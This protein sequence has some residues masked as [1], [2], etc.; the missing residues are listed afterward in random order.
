MEDPPRPDA[1]E[2]VTACRR[3]HVKLA[4]IPLWGQADSL[5]RTLEKARAA[6]IDVTAD[7]Y[8]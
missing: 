3:A 5:I 8:P 1:H 7:I 6:G 4:M 2:A